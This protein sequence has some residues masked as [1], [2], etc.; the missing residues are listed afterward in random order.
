MLLE[1]DLDGLLLVGAFVDATIGRLVERHNTPVVLVDAYA[2]EH[3]YDSV[4]SDNFRGAHEAVSYLIE[5]G[6]RHIGL[7]GSLPTTY[8]S[9]EE[10]RRGYLRALREHGIAPPYFADSHIPPDQAAEAT[11]DLLRRFPRITAL[12]CC[13]DALAIAVMQAAQALGRAVPGDLSIVG[14]DDI[15]LA[16]HVTPA[17]TT[18]RVDKLS[19]GRLAVQLLVNRAT[20]PATGRVTTVLRPALV[21][22][23]SVAAPVTE[24]HSQSFGGV[25]V[26]F[27]M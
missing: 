1:D 7:V 4:V 17:L 15:D 20:F 10:R 6:H 18:M 21:K 25:V 2:A 23:R 16:A 26:R 11:A 22:R 8:P 14:F 27:L 24:S 3:I 12:F 19:M 13:N 5:C 9:I